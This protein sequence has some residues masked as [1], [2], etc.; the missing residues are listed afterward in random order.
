M[1][2]QPFAQPAPASPVLSGENAFED[3]EPL[4]LKVQ[5]LQ[6]LVSNNDSQS[7]HRH[8]CCEIVFV[9]KGQGQYYFD[10]ENYP[11]SEKTVCCTPPGR[12]HKLDPQPGLQGY[13]LSF[14][15]KNLYLSSANL[16]QPFYAPQ[17]SGLSL[18]G[19]VKQIDQRSGDELTGL[20][21]YMYK[22]YGGSGVLRQEM[23]T[24]LLRIFLQYLEKL[25]DTIDGLS[26][27][28]GR[29][30][31]VNSFYARLE[32]NFHCNKTVH[33]YADDMCLSPNHLN[34]IIKASTGFSAS[35]HIRQR[36]MLEAK[37]FAVHS[38]ASMKEIAY[39]LGFT[40]IAYF[41]K[42]FKQ[43][44]GISFSKYRQ[45]YATA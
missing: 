35:Y 45:L 42:Y 5:T 27:K 28:S 10:L 41:S 17:F 22:E 13:L 24:G 6:E 31:Q 12:L 7:H 43:G 15:L 9:V 2:H 3:E 30:H 34:H 4:Y 16:A 18:D 44:A 8:S 33:D 1:F 37:R 26:K 11:L 39:S 40:D 38:V 19:F 32:A 14:C 25:P 21:N 29:M 36:K 20:L 23:L